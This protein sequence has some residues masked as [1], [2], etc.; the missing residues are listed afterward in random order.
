MVK[1]LL[2]WIKTF[3]LAIILAILIKNFIATP[4]VVDGSSMQPTLTDGQILIVNSLSYRFKEPK[5]G[6]V[7]VFKHEEV[8]VRDNWL[9]RL[10]N[11]DGLVK[12]IIGVP[13]DTVLIEYGKVYVNGEMLEEEYVDY[14]ITGSYGPVTLEDGMLFVLGDNRYPHGSSDSRFF[15]PVSVDSILGRADLSV[16]PVVGKVD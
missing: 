9:D 16:F 3:V 14:E 7:I 13:G 8:P 1:E 10:L 6:D 15:G 11:R 12:R 4:Y 2:S 5:R